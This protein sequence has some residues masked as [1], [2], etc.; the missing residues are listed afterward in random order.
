MAL[1]SRLGGFSMLGL[2]SFEA[3][4]VLAVSGIFLIF[5]GV[6]VSRAFN[7]TQSPDLREDNEN[8]F[9]TERP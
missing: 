9:Q 4:I 1:R 7:V 8:P 5:V 2:G 6:A 3:L